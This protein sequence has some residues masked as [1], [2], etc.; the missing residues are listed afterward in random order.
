VGLVAA[1]VVLEPGA[2]AAAG[3][4]GCSS[5]LGDTGFISGWPSDRLGQV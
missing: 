4:T 2:A 1:P 3:K 5:A